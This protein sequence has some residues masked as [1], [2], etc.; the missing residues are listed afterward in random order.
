MPLCWLKLE[1]IKNGMPNLHFQLRSRPFITSTISD[2]EQEKLY[3]NKRRTMSANTKVVQ[4]FMFARPV[5]ATAKV[6]KH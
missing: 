4:V 6:K 3:L 2:N 5:N 1:K